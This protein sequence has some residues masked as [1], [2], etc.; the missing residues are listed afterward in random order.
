M[1]STQIDSEADGPL[2][3]IRCNRPKMRNRIGPA[4]HRELLEAWTRF[5]ERDHPERRRDGPPATPVWSGTED[6]PPEPSRAPA[7]PQATGMAGSA[8]ASATARSAAGG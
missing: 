7:P 6:R 8:A 4:T 5:R 1:S 2:R 3:I